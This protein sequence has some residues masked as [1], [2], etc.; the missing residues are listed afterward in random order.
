M[1][2]L[3]GVRVP[4]DVGV[5]G[6]VGSTSAEWLPDARRAPAMKGCRR[7]TAP[8]FKTHL[9][10]LLHD[11]ARRPHVVIIMLGSMDGA[12][13]ATPPLAGS[14]RGTADNV[15][16]LTRALLDAGVSTVCVCLAPPSAPDAAPRNTASIAAVR[17]VGVVVARRCCPL[18]HP[19]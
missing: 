3:P 14:A 17:A 11:P 13:H 19:L 18:L 4:V 8:L 5:V 15:E 10:P 6:H 1:Q 9:A 12:R 16:A 7:Q 2:A